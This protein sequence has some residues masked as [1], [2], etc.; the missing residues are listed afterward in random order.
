MLMSIMTCTH[1]IHIQY[2][3]ELVTYTFWLTTDNSNLNRN[4]VQ[5]NSYPSPSRSD[6]CLNERG[7]IDAL[8]PQYLIFEPRRRLIHIH[9]PYSNNMRVDLRGCGFYGLPWTLDIQLGANS[10]W[11]I[12]KHEHYRVRI[13]GSVQMK[14]E[15]KHNVCIKLRRPTDWLVI[16]TQRMLW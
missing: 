7:H 9:I 5:M 13:Y 14:W 4:C 8:L 11:I 1:N 6:L 15:R 16:Y 10:S 2:G 12:A 3:Y